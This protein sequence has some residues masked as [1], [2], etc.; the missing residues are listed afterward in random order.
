MCS[1]LVI[2]RTQKR[3]QH[4]MSHSFV[5][6]VYDQVARSNISLIHRLPFDLIDP[7]CCMYKYIISLIFAW[8]FVL[9]VSFSCLISFL[10]FF[11]FSSSSSSFCLCC[12]SLFLYFFPFLFISS[13]FCLA[14]Q[15]ISY[16]YTHHLFDL[17]SQHLCQ[18]DYKSVRIQ[19]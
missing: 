12:F 9:F 2:F 3:N 19:H 6:L 15:D 14:K 7:T 16:I 11:P 8:V 10:I 13:C 17:P 18:Q 5:W 1:Y 4:Q